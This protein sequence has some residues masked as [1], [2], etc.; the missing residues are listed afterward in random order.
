MGMMTVMQSNFSTSTG[1]ISG[2]PSA[3]TSSATYTITATNTGGDATTTVTIVVNDVIPSS[4]SYSGSPFTLTKDSAMT[5]ATPTSSGGTVVSW[6]VSP[7]LPAGLVIDSST[8]VISGTP[9]AITASATYTITAT[10]TGG[11][12]TTTVTI[13]VNDITKVKILGPFLFL[14]GPRWMSGST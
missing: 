9:T 11:D 12:A 7:S 5:A 4:V 14:I 6:A 1:E 8:G 13:V 10:N 2:T 3:V